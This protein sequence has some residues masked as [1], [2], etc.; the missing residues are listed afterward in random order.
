MYFPAALN[1]Y[2]QRLT[3]LPRL[4]LID[5]YLASQLLPPFGFSVGLVASL[6]VAIAYL[7]DL[8]NKIIEKNLPLEQ[9][10]EILLLKVPEFLAYALP[11]SVMLATLMTFGRLSND[12][13]LVALRCCGVSLFRIA[14]PVVGLSL[15]VSGLTFGISEWLVPA[16][17]YRD[18]AILVQSIQEEHTFW[19]NRDIFYPEF[20]TVVTDSGAEVRRLKRLVYAERFDG[21]KME[22]LTV[23]Q[24]SGTQLQ[25]IIISDQATWNQ[26][27]GS[28]DF[29]K[30]TVY[31]LKKDTS[32][33]EAQPF[34]QRNLQLPKSAFD[35]AL[36][37]RDPYEMNIREAR[38][39][40]DILRMI[41]DQKKLTF[42]EVR[43][44]Q[45]AA[46]PFVCVV[47]GL[48]GTAIGSRPQQMSRATGLGLSVFIIFAYYLLGFMTGSLGMAGLLS[49]GWAA[50]LPNLIGLGVGIVLLYRFN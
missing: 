48:V 38:E 41:G 39:Y 33:L 28:W 17:N 26:Q 9:A 15:V 32:Y 6:G 2:L 8:A 44:E 50:W 42:F 29:F 40:M 35:F 46:F 49:P 47:F 5:R 7:S 22:E 21:Q 27:K 4:A 34:Q 23:L 13:E 20:E 31:P 10:V 43:T 24:W 36:Q 14:L 19:Q 37:G 30:G 16:A 3:P 25:K 45:K 12:S 1:R 18:T 11:I